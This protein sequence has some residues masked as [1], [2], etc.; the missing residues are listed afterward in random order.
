MPS[1]KIIPPHF[2]NQD[3]PT[4]MA[5]VFGDRAARLLE[6]TPQE[7]KVDKLQYSGI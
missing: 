3:Y 2:S 1:W 6:C 4:L 5:C 7:L